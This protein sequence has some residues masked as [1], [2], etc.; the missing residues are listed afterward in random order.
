MKE[1][2]YTIPLTESLEAQDE[3]PF[4]VARQ[5]LEKEAL[6]FTLGSC[7][8]YMES[9][10]REQTDAIGFCREHMKAMYL[11]GNTLGNAHILHTHLKKSNQELEKKLKDFTPAK[12]GLFGRGKKQAE[13]G[14]ASTKITGWIREREKSCYICK[15]IDETYDRYLDTFLYLFRTNPEFVERVK[16]SK[17]FCYTHFG[18]LLEKGEEKL[19]A[20]QFE[21]MTQILF[22]LMTANMK[23]VEEDLSWLIDK[24]DYR[25]TDAPWKNSKDAL[26]RGMQKM[27]GGYPAEPP[28]HP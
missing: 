11:Y 25:Y 3:C 10:V 5:K 21:E 6:D 8:S 24:F 14:L 1:K 26:P 2:L 18:D 13:G 28:H 9:D 19:N 22:P 23:R 20:A 12:A 17:G 15:Q 16:N 4:C 27:H 7:A